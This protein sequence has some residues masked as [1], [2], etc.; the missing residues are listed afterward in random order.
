[1]T[2]LTNAM[3]HIRHNAQL[4]AVAGLD[5]EEIVQ[6]LRD[7]TALYS[8]TFACGEAGRTIALEAQSWRD[9]AEAESS[10][11]QREIARLL[12]ILASNLRMKIRY[13]EKPLPMK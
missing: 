2:I 10:D 12:G 11:S 9:S 8:D 13:E 6:Q 7:T 1:M 5:A 3:T 4:L